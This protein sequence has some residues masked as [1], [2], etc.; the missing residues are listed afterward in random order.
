[1]TT[2]HAERRSTARHEHADIEGIDPLEAILAELTQPIGDDDRADGLHEQ[3]G[4]QRAHRDASPPARPSS[5]CRRSAAIAAPAAADSGPM[6]GEKNRPP[7]W[8]DPPS[9]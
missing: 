8:R 5:G 3:D 2:E 9:A 1:M 7:H 4:G 6:I